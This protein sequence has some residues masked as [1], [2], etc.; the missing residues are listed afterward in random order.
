LRP[1]AVLLVATLL[2]A[3]SGAS[4]ASPRIVLQ[5][6]MAGVRLGMTVAQARAVLGAGVTTK[7]GSND[8]GPY[9]L[10]T[11]RPLRL[12]VSLQGRRRVTNLSITGPGPRTA[13]GI[14]VGSTEA[15]V[16]RRIRGVRC[17]EQVGIRLCEVGRAQ[18]GRTVSDL[19]ITA[20]RVSR[21]NIGVVID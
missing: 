18:P 4:A 19:F 15:Q 8:F 16:R 3:A 5:H 20:G 12:T 17:A 14:G 10:L 13:G 6:E 21:V 11:S 7:R 1:A 2:A 9:L